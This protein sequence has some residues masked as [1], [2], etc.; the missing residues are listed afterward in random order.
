MPVP[1]ILAQLPLFSVLSDADLER[2][3]EISRTRLY[4][5]RETIFRSGD[6]GTALYVIESGEVKLALT[7]LSGKE[8]A[9]ALLGPGAFFGELSLLDGEPRSA[10][11]MARTECRLLMIGRAE[12]L[13]FLD[14]RPGLARALLAALSQRLRRTTELIEDAGFLDIGGQLASALLQL[15]E[16]HVRPG[17]DGVVATAPRLTQAEL[18]GFVGATRESVNKW[19]GI[20]ERQGVLKR[21]RGGITV[22]KPEELRRRIC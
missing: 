13:D 4:K 12:F 2:L 15:T 10:D 6:E 17:P 21:E 22:L 16:E 11:A 19:L 8:R 1:S 20:F 7:S 5:K 9:L 3:A 18:A 14:K